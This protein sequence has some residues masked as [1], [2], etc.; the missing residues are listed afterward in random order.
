M[1]R[2]PTPASIPAPLINQA[3]DEMIPII[4][5]ISD[6]FP[7]P[8]HPLAPALLRLINWT[9]RTQMKLKP[10]LE[11]SSTTRLRTVK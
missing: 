9:G 3:F 10:W 8:G 7:A 5:D 6:R 1:P 11:P 2:K 4:D